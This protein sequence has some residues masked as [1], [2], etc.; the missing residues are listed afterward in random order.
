MKNLFCFLLTLCL[1]NTNQ[2]VNKYIY[3]F[4]NQNARSEEQ[5]NKQE[6]GS[7]NLIESVYN[8]KDNSCTIV[9]ECPADNDIVEFFTN[10]VQTLTTDPKVRYSNVIQLLDQETVAFLKDKE[11]FVLDNDS[12][13]IF[14]LIL[15]QDQ[16]CI[17]LVMR[18][19]TKEERNIYIK[20]KAFEY[21]MNKKALAS[22][23]QIEA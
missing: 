23:Q 9:N 12:S 11:F 1:Y 10:T 3:T 17:A 22:Y 8:L 6:D 13:Q 16:D 4:V 5:I 2:C 20:I 14:I 21:A 18:E 7:W 15:T 19:A